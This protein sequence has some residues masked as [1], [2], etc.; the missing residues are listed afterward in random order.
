MA[1]VTAITKAKI[2]LPVD[3]NA[4]M[5]AEVAEYQ[6]RLSAPSGDRISVT[7]GKMLRLPDGTEVLSTEAVVVEFVSANYYYSEGY[8][9]DDIVPPDC[10]SLSFE[11]GGMVPSDNSPNKQAESCA[12]CWANQFKSAPNKKSKACQ[13]TKLLALLPTDATANTPINIL[14]V[15]PTGAKYFDAHANSVKNELKMP[16]R[17]V[18][19]KIGCSADVD[20][21][22]LRFAT[23][24]ATPKDLLLLAH[25]RLQE[26][27]DRL[28]IEPDVSA[29]KAEATKK[30]PVK[31]AAGGRR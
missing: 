10:F 12:A 6:K 19:T 1:K 27:K 14:K 2:N 24:A 13:N 15:S 22:S 9:R 3:I 20:Y 30:T 21:A 18:I 11:S 4:Q 25:S 28:M 23:E 29:A 8:D 5:A 17:G 7:Q 16:V 26:A 31:K